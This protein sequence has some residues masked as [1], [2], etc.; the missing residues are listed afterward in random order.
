M[1]K[2][3]FNTQQEYWALCNYLDKNGY[4]QKEAPQLSGM[5]GQWH[6]IIHPETKTYHESVISDFSFPTQCKTFTEVIKRLK[7]KY[8][9]TRLM[10]NIS[11]LDIVNEWNH[12]GITNFERG[13]EIMSR[14]HDDWLYT[15]IQRCTDDP[16]LQTR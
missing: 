7:N 10:Y 2:F 9:R 6:I 4:V 15:E 8:Y 14:R 13:A 1:L 11:G 3:D 12:I 16:Y 5:F